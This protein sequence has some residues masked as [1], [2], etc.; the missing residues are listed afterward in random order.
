MAR[1]IVKDI[2]R[3]I[4]NNDEDN[5]DTVFG[6]CIEHLLYIEMV[7]G[8]LFVVDGWWFI[9]GYNLFDYLI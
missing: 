1:N 3:L 4:H 5:S 2:Y 8:W 6:T 7:D 9:F